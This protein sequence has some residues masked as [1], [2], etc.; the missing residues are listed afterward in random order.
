MHRG[1]RIGSNGAAV[2]ICARRFSIARFCISRIRCALPASL[3]ATRLIRRFTCADLVAWLLESCQLTAKWPSDEQRKNQAAR[4]TSTK[5][6][7]AGKTAAKR[8]R[9][10]IAVT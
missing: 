4:A 8:Q 2:A 7:R 3:C 10:L 5:A 6:W 1:V 9:G